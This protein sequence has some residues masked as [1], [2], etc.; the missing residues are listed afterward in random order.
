MC[1]VSLLLCVDKSVA[2]FKVMDEQKEKWKTIN[3]NLGLENCI[4]VMM[5]VL[6]LWKDSYVI[7]E[8]KEEML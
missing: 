2:L 8:V 1:T 6:L 7:R 3:K 5:I 4:L